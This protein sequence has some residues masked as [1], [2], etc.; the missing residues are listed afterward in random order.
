MRRLLV[1]TLLL[2]AATSWSGRIVRLYDLNQEQAVALL[3]SGYDVTNLDARRG[4]VDVMLDREQLSTVSLLAPRHEVMPEEWAHLM[5]ES[6]LGMGYYYDP[7]ENWAFWCGLAAAHPD[8]VD[9][10]VTIGESFE[11]RDIY[12]VRLTS[13]DGPSY[14]PVI[15][16]S[17]LIHARE[18]GGNSVLI[19]FAMWLTDNYSSDTMA[20]WI[21]DNTQVYFV[22]VANPDGYEYNM[23]NGGNH[24]KNM[25]FS[26]PVPSDGIDLNRNWGYMWGYDDYGSSPYPYDET[27]RGSAAFSEDETQVQ[28]DFTNLIQPIAAMNYHTYGGYLLY[29]WGYNNTPTPDQGT[30]ESWGAAMTQYN[31]YEYG[32]AGQV[33]YPVNGDQNDWSYYSGAGHPKVMAFSPEVDDNGFWGG[34]ND[35]TL[36]ASFCAECRYM[37]IWLC[38]TAPGF[39]G[40]EEE[41]SHCIEPCGLSIG[42]LWPNPVGS[43][44]ELSIE[45]SS[46]SA[47]RFEVSLHDLTGRVVAR[48]ADAAIEPGSNLVTV[49]LPGGV[50]S[51]LYVLR[52]TSG[53]LEDRALVTLLR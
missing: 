36:I 15:Y 30:F 47:G 19:D 53:G 5:P 22:P 20:E 41:D 37:N 51:G 34:Q 44:G 1:P 28:R 24:R 50:P 40:V 48:V 42:S 16:F 26:V 33:L 52:G 21:L 11:G 32:R 25:N 35:T 38:M 17:S 9:T 13:P 7:D 10:P 45:V 46:L 4:F 14:K 18:P 8:L 49:S 39:V 29:P 31:G 27:Y 3:R 2:I 6:S 43:S 23:P 12:S